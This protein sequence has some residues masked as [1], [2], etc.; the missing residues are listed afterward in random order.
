MT[1]RP[2]LLVV[3][4]SG[5]LYG[6]DRTLLQALPALTDAF[7]V[8]VA[9]PFDGPVVPLLETGG[10]RVQV[11]PDFALRRR[12]FSLQ[13]VGPWL[14][15]GVAAA[16]ALRRL[17]RTDPVALVYANSLASAVVGALRPLLRVPILCHVH[18]CPGAPAWLPK[19]LLPSIAACSDI[20]VC[21]SR[22]T[23]DFAA[24]YAPRL[25]TQ[26]V[27]IYNGI[28]IPPLV[29]PPPSSRLRIGCVARI[30][31]NKGHAVLLEAARIAMA[32]GSDWE[33][34]FY[35]DALAEHRNLEERLHR[36]VEESGLSGLV[37]W[38]GFVA[39]TSA[40]YEETDVSVVP[41][42]VPEGFSLVCAESL[43]RGRPVV[44]TG[45]GGPSEVV[46]DGETGFI[47]PRN[48][49]AALAAALRRLEDPA[50]RADMGAKGRR[51]MEERFSVDRY[52]TE[53]RD[54]CLA[55]IKDREH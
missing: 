6:S 43:V 2:H 37:H 16:A 48:D 1:V 13:G 7:R 12:N 17:H 39:D 28:E 50:I 9:A 22:Y 35:G 32:G 49:S 25:S 5:E 11:I 3:T 40:L 10:A 20:V 41:S 36:Q 34:H 53:L 8:T 27:V 33:L 54:C 19:V 38:H 14:G 26:G 15:R 31:P 42:V 29:L 21:N 51:R 47:A 24:T 55:A 52:A 44:V 46:V 23:R 45:P 4:A 18:E 30:H